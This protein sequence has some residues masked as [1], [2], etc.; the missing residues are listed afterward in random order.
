MF[1]EF[2]H[3]TSRTSDERNQKEASLQLQGFFFFLR[4]GR[5][6]SIPRVS[7][8]E[9]GCSWVEL[10]Q[11]WKLTDPSG[12][13]ENTLARGQVLELGEGWRQGGACSMCCS[14]F[15][16]P[17][18]DKGLG[19]VRGQ[20][21]GA[22]GR[23]EHSVEG[24]EKDDSSHRGLLACSGTTRDFSLGCPLSRSERNVGNVGNLMK[25]TSEENSNEVGTTDLLD[26]W[27]GLLVSTQ[28]SLARCG[29]RSEMTS[30][31]IVICLHQAFLL[32]CRSK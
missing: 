14:C 24:T 6:I 15:K 19:K 2:I 31:N 28:C 22:V 10:F 3:P 27:S 26:T 25:G 5:E 21:Q 16:N 20:V 17:V 7:T 23:W 1:E 30:L 4:R 29:H 8:Q 11:W 12:R 32:G 13:T 9:S 18:K